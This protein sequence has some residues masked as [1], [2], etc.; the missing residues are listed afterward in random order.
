MDEHLVGVTFECDEPAAAR[1]D[2]EGDL[3]RGRVK[4]CPQP[5]SWTPLR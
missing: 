3:S 5:S 1:T 4:R 2:M